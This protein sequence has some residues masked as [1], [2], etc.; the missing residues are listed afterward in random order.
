L[1]AKLIPFVEIIAA[2][3]NGADI[4]AIVECVLRRTIGDECTGGQVLGRFIVV[5]CEATE[6]AVFLLSRK[7]AG[8]ISC[9]SGLDFNWID[10]IDWIDNMLGTAFIVDEVMAGV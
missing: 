8:A 4:P 7:G 10:R 6:A 9:W 2:P 1:N 5:K 3:S